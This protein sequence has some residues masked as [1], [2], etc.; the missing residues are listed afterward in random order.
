MRWT[1]RRG[2]VGLLSQWQHCPRRKADAEDAADASQAEQV[3]II[4][5]KET[6]SQS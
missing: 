5:P 1:S 6:L 4:G 2:R 3:P